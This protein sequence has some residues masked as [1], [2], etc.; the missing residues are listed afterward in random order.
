MA[1]DGEDGVMGEVGDGEAGAT[2]ADCTCRF[3][4]SF[5]P[6][7]N[8]MAA[9]VKSAEVK[10]SNDRSADENAMRCKSHSAPHL[11]SDGTITRRTKMFAVSLQCSR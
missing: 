9:E 8:D 4:L 6:K 2:V 1:G 5:L 7:K 10:R 3:F 11:T